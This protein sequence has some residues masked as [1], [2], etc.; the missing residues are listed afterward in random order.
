MNQL[1]QEG[2]ILH[3][4][5]STV[6]EDVIRRAHAVCPV[7]AVQNIY[8]MLERDTEELF[9]ALEKLNI[10]L[11]THCPLAKGFL[12]AAYDKNSVFPEGD[13]RGRMGLFA[14]EGIQKHQAVLDLIQAKAAE[15]NATPAQIAWRGSWGRSRGSFPSP[16]PGSWSVWWKTA[17]RR[18][19]T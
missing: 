7:T 14:E 5:L 18:R 2:K 9:P 12:T 13:W 6:T 1:I 16:A 17:E 19:Y 10:G 15:K 8:S 11:V 4:G 3:W